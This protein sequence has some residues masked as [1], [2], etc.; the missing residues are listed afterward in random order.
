M[1]TDR[2]KHIDVRYHFVRDVIEQ[3]L[4]KGCNISTHDNFV[5]MMTKFS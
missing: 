5:D 2:K 4:I 1:L 3:G